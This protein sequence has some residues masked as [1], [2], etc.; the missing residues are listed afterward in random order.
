MQD[1]GIAVDRLL[2]M[3]LAK[4]QRPNRSTVAGTVGQGCN[5]MNSQSVQVGNWSL[6]SLAR[7]H[8]IGGLE[9]RQSPGSGKSISRSWSQLPEG[10]Q[11]F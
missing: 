5:G 3:D 9:E 8:I 11:V 7:S 1:A 4:T 10:L 6:G 2:G